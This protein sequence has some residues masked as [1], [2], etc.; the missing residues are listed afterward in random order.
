MDAEDLPG[1]GM[2]RSIA[3]TAPTRRRATSTMP[4]LKP[5]IPSENSLVTPET[6]DYHVILVPRI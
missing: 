4:S 6:T 1:K 2:N 5:T 3:T